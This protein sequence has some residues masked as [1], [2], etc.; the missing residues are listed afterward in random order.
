[1]QIFT[2]DR[3]YRYFTA[4]IG[5]ILQEFQA[6]CWNYCIMPNHFHLTVQPRL[7]NLSVMLHRLHSRYAQWWNRRH[8][9][10]GHVFQGRFKDQIVQ[11]ER[12]L[13][14]LCRYVARNPVRANLV[15]QPEDWEWSSFAATIGLKPPPSFLNI[16]LTLQQFGPGDDGILCTRFRDFVGTE[17]EEGI[18]DRLRSTEEIIG[19]YAFKVA[20]NPL[21]KQPEESVIV[22][23]TAARVLEA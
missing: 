5:D 10:V 19:D 14:C 2:D 13:L 8:D 11:H 23:Y 4:L 20:V 1:M 7:P 16:G 17:L 9:H 15:T 21:L 12:Y 6:D 22:P 3:D 18:E